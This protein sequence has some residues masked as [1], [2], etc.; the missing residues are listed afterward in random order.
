MRSTSS[1]RPETWSAC[2]CVSSTATIGMPCAS[3]SATYSSTRSTCGSTTAKLAL[4]LA[5]EQIRGA[6]GLVVQQLAEEHAASEDVIKSSTI[7]SLLNSRYGARVQGRALRGDRGDGQGV[8][9]P[10]PARADRPAR[11]GPAHRR[12]AGARERPV[13]RERLAAPAGAARRRRRR[14]ASATAP[15]CA[16]RSPATTCCALWLALRDASATRLAEVERAARDYLGD[17][18]EAIGRD[19]LLAAAAARRRRA[20]RRAPRRGVRG[21]PHRRRALDPDRRARASASPSCPADRE[22]VAYCRGPFCAY[23]H[24]AVRTPARRGPL[25]ATARRGLARMAARRASTDLIRPKEIAMSTTPPTLDTRSSSS[26]SSSMYQEVALEPEREFH[27]ETGRAARRAARLP[28]RGPRPDPGRRDRLVR[29]RRATSSTSRR[30]QPGE[31]VLD[32]GSGSGTDS[33]LAALAA[34]ADG[35]V[36]GVDMTDEQLAKATRLAAEGGFEQRRV[37][38]RLHRGAARRGRERSTA[39]SRTA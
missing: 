18:V 14:R 15:A 32:L 3:A 4:A 7:N 1:G 35:R 8:R 36:I 27:F 39:S 10:A 30:S 13:D 23:A 22:I 24:E 21:R 5:A 19:E 33:F 20:R 34:G 16:T 9:E 6:G 25:R 37:P 17:E 12:R 11:A 26:A 31:T 38:R 2:T 29:R 28:A